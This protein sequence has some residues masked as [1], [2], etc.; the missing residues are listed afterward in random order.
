MRTTWKARRVHVSG[1]TRKWLTGSW[2]SKKSVG[3]VSLDRLPWQTNDTERYIY[4][5]IYI[6]RLQSHSAPGLID[7]DDKATVASKASPQRQ[8]VVP[9]K[10]GVTSTTL[11]PKTCKRAYYTLRGLSTVHAA[12]YMTPISDTDTHT[13]TP[14]NKNWTNKKRKEKSL[15]GSNLVLR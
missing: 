4:I 14:K 11:L 1:L 6:Y 8:W 12:V 3:S 2:K 5:Y 7:W 10:R 13:H 9:L 15:A